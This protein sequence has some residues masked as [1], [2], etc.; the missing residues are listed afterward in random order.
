MRHRFPGRGS[1]CL[2]LDDAWNPLGE[3]DHVFKLG[4]IKGVPGENDVPQ[5]LVYLVESALQS[6]DVLR[7]TWMEGERKGMMSACRLLE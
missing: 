5:K 1:C 2:G 4:P 7:G 3:V 6:G